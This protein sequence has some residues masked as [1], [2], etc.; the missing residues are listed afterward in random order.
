MRPCGSRH[1]EHLRPD[2]VGLAYRRDVDQSSLVAIALAG[3]WI[4]YL[5]PHR[6]RY[7]QQLLDSCVED[8]FSGELRVLRVA[9]TGAAA[10]A[11]SSDRDAAVRSTGRIHPV[12]QRVE[13]PREQ[14]AGLERGG[15][16]MERPH[17]HRDRAVAD[18]AR[19]TAS[20]HAARAAYL[21]RR[22]AA[23]RRRAVLT[24]L[25][26]LAVVAGWGAVATGA[27]GIVAGAVPTALL[28]GVLVLG[29]R[30]VIAGARADARW[31]A[32]EGAR[33]PVA[34]AVRAARSSGAGRATVV[35]RAVH[36]SEA[37]TEVMA[38][39]GE[40]RDSTGVA[41]SAATV[42]VEAEAAPVAAE[43]VAGEFVAER[44]AARP[45]AVEDRPEAIGPTPEETSSTWVPVPVPRPAYTLKPMARRPEPAP[46]VL[47]A[48]PVAVA[49]DVAA[50]SDESGPVTDDAAPTTGGLDLDA[51]LARRRA[52][53]E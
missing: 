41:S 24:G 3:L 31:A 5:V 38:R 25:L 8:R 47:D 29:R 19:H 30:A 33:P 32:G 53:G 49:D 26:L 2:G 21:A 1:A 17:V 18:A 4:A 12:R 35:G 22:A 16:T 50:G 13:G 14:S 11:P 52:A 9:G 34:D 23:A 43:P 44:V 45:D 40:R 7:R 51:I 28:A 39:V 27:L 37:T 10:H 15:R 46:L 6:L 42:A 36:P 48:D 20:E